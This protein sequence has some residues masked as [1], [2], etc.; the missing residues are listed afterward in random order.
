MPTTINIPVHFL[1]E[2]AAARFR[3]V[4][5]GNDDDVLLAVEKTINK[6]IGVD[7]YEDGAQVLEPDEA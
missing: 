3:A 4:I 6:S 1:N 2:D 5:T 7:F